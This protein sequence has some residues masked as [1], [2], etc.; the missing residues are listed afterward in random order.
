MAGKRVLHSDE[1]KDAPTAFWMV[2][3]LV[4]LKGVR[5]EYN[6]AASRD[7]AMERQTAVMTETY[8]AAKL[9]LRTVERKVECVADCSVQRG[10]G[11]MDAWKVVQKVSTTVVEMVSTKEHYAVGQRVE[12]RVGVMVVQKEVLTA[13][14]MAEQMVA[15]TAMVLLD[16]MVPKTERM[17]AELLGGKKV[18]V[19]VAQWVGSK[20]LLRVGEMV[21]WKEDGRAGSMELPMAVTW[22]FSRVVSMDFWTVSATDPA[23]VAKLIAWMVARL[24]A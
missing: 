1:E 24:V 20:A 9:G 12:W 10:A 7:V 19:S 13:L 6:T 22:A 4:A 14:A 17:S 3:P 23:K 8:S 16:A 21:V 18:G 11:T 2:G 5:M 15:W